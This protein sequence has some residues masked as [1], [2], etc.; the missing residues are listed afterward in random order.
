MIA[1]YIW[2]DGFGT[3]RS[4]IRCIDLQAVVFPEDIP[5]WNYDGSSTGQAGV[6]SSEIEL[7]PVAM[8]KSPF[9][10]TDVL[11]L[12]D[13]LPRREFAYMMK[14][15]TLSPRFAFEQEFYLESYASCLKDRH[16]KK[17]ELSASGN[18]YCRTAASNRNYRTVVETTLSR[19]LEAGLSITG[20]NSEVSPGQWELQIDDYCIAACDGLWMLRFILMRTAEEAGFDVVFHP[21]P[22]PMLSGSGCHVNYSDE[23]TI[24]DSD[25]SGIYR[26]KKIIDA[27][28]IMHKK[29]IEKYGEDNRLRLTGKHETQHYNFFSWG[30]GDRGAS[31]RIPKET[32]ERGYGYFEDRRPAANCNPY[33]VA[34]VIYTTAKMV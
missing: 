4:K 31:I 12:C 26:I 28:A 11:V 23:G 29:D 14:T 1:E 32:D 5:K 3:L 20:M 6:Q 18:N 9:A 13:S 30:V 8:Y 15:D 10:R 24:T 17:S 21:K 25:R 22:N 2:I 19:C 16:V 33:I 7:V 27:L 34:G